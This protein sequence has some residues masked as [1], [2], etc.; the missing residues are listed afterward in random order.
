MSADLG[1]AVDDGDV[2]PGGIS[3]ALA[4]TT[5][6]ALA[7]SLEMQAQMMTLI[8]QVRLLRDSFVETV[9]LL[10]G[11]EGQKHLLLLSRG[12]PDFV[13]ADVTTAPIVESLFT[14][15]RRNGWQIQAFD[16][17]GV[18]DPFGGG[19]PAL[20]AP[21]PSPPGGVGFQDD[22][23]LYLADGTGGAVF[24]NF[25]DIGDATSQMLGRSQV[26]YLLGFTVVGQPADG[27]YHRLR[28]RLR[29]SARGVRVVH[30]EGYHASLPAAERSPL[31]RRLDV[32]ERL[33]GDEEG[34]TLEV[35][36]LATPVATESGQVS[37]FVEVP[38]AQLQPLAGEEHRTLR[39]QAFA[40]DGS[41]V[42]TDALA[43]EVTLDL[44]KLRATL[45]AGGVRVHGALR[46][47]P[48]ELRVRLAVED[49]EEGRSWLGTLPV[50]VP[51]PTAPSLGGPLFLDLGGG[52]VASRHD[53][54]ATYPWRLGGRD[55]LPRISPRLTAGERAPLLLLLQGA[56]DA[57]RLTSRVLTA[58]G[59][60]VR[61]GELVLLAREPGEHG[62]Q[63]V[64][65]AFAPG[66]LPPGRYR[67]EVGIDG[68]A[69]RASGEAWFEVTGTQP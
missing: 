53:P 47:A 2:L 58:D 44:G 42:L 25:S 7:Q 49:V 19:T 63:R 62:A 13:L 10:R 11:V 23:L 66:A 29:G 30:R 69:G 45:A 16:V 57:D 37:F 28:V 22:T 34:G 68:T 3:S 38:G 33:L 18:P 52:W 14:A 24:E 60:E 20:G 35:A 41:A 15:F 43:H 5:A 64:L 59:E 55:V 65:A 54:A 50:R 48:G 8:A 12:F 6:T 61:G 39:L 36:A 32:A 40:L 46:A 31:E 9:T 56:A 26:T 17:G 27:R 4:A 51:G 67:L 1:D 21:D